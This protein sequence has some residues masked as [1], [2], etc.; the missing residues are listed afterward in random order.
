MSF[1]E[2]AATCEIAQLNFLWWSTLT[3]A[4]WREL[5]LKPETINA[6]LSLLGQHSLSIIMG[7]HPQNME[8]HSLAFTS[9][10]IDGK[11][12]E[13]ANYLRHGHHERCYIEGGLAS[14]TE[15]LHRRMW[16]QNIGI[17]LPCR[18]I[19]LSRTDYCAYDAI[20]ELCNLTC[21]KSYDFRFFH[22]TNSHSRAT[23]ID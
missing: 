11:I 5:S 23:P 6:V 4:R 22:A 9:A 16:L 17:F 3:K 18:A 21:H 14:K 10:P 1:R 19:V 20:A 15:F 12:S 7:N 13:K 8:R 2:S